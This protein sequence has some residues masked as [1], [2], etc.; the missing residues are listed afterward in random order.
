MTESSPAANKSMES[1]RILQWCQ[2]LD[3]PRHATNEG[4]DMY[5]EGSRFLP[6]RE[7]Q[8]EI[9]KFRALEVCVSELQRKY[10]P[11]H[12]KQ[13]LTQEEC[14]LRREI[15]T[16]WTRLKPEYDN[17]LQRVRR[18]RDQVDLCRAYRQ[19][20]REKKAKFEAAEFASMEVQTGAVDHTSS[21][22]TFKLTTNELGQQRL[23]EPE[24]SPWSPYSHVDEGARSPKDV[25]G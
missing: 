19:T 12:K 24:N 4:L 10:R 5:K 16:E 14:Q 8:I 18:K 15:G 9:A 17:L 1:L 20:S 22:A 21:M 2:E 7:A 11:L 13:D 23:V 3:L 6:N 25:S